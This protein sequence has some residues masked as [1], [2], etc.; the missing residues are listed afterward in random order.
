[1]SYSYTYFEASLNP[2]FLKK[3]QQKTNQTNKQENPTSWQLACS[4]HFLF[5]EFLHF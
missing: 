4:G 2:V 1:M 5:F 3:K